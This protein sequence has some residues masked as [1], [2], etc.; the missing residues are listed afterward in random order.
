MY[1]FYPLCSDTSVPAV[2]TKSEIRQRRKVSKSERLC[3]SHQTWWWVCRHSAIGNHWTAF[4]FRCS[5]PWFSSKDWQQF[6]EP[7][8]GNI[9][10]HFSVLSEGNTLFI[11]FL[12]CKTILPPFVIRNT[13]IQINL[14]LELI[15][16]SP[17]FQFIWISVLIDQFIYSIETHSSRL[18]AVKYWW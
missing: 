6:Y 17:T 16:W 1:L 4:C 5:H 8:N 14:L 7:I 13:I 2:S 3:W 9:I 10:S 15:Q 18:T 11:F 12:L